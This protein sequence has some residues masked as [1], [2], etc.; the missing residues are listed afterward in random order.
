[1]SPYQ[2]IA[3]YLVPQSVFTGVVKVHYVDDEDIQWCYEIT[4]FDILYQLI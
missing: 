4:Q 3:V 1:M 2:T